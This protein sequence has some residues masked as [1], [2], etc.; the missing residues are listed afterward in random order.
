M[1]PLVTGRRSVTQATGIGF[2]EGRAYSR[3][4]R[5]MHQGVRKTALARSRYEEL[6]IGKDAEDARLSKRR[7]AR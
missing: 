4:S 5:R 7:V 1:T 2:A 6:I 3:T